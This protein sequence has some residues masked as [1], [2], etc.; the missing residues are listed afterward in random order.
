M[1]HETLN[2]KIIQ[3][4]DLHFRNPH[5]WYPDDLHGDPLIDPLEAE[6]QREEWGEDVSDPNY[7]AAALDEEETHYGAKLGSL[8][9]GLDKE[10][11]DEDEDPGVEPSDDEDDH[12]EIE[13]EYE[14]RQ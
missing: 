4:P 10:V 13:G 11:N 3:I 6:T 2:N 1:R 5:A 12:E 8:A 7:F 9:V 14:R